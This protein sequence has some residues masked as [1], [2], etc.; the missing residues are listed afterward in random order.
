MML[1]CYGSSC[2]DNLLSL[3]GHLRKAFQWLRRWVGVPLAFAMLVFIGQ[4]V[5]TGWT[6]I[7]A[8]ASQIRREWLLAGIG[9]TAA[10]IIMLGWN[11]I[12]I[13]IGRGMQVYW[14]NTMALYLLTNLTRYLPGGIWHFVGRT[15]SL[16][17]QG[18]GSRSVIASLVL[19]QMM[20]L[21]SA[22]AIGFSLSGLNIHIALAAGL[23][24][25]AEIVLVLLAG[26]AAGYVKP[27]Y[28]R[29]S[30]CRRLG[31]WTLLTLSYNLF[32]IVNGSATVCLFAALV[33][34]EE[35]TPFICV[36]L[37]G[38]TA[39]SWAV[40]YMV[41]FVPGGWGVREVVFIHLLSRNFSGD[42]AIILPV[43]SRL[44]QILAE[45]LCGTIFLLA[46]HLVKKYPDKDNLSPQ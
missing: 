9:L 33:G 8:T 37:V 46:W 12:F 19:E 25:F 17:K 39:L 44:T 34:L 42:V 31:L 3:N 41:L 11:W 23:S 45:L 24:V 40:G 38:Q 7:Q 36:T 1:E 10:S 32:W 15:A 14:P 2:S 6:T 22:G 13:L 16:A 26:I 18:H 35:T 21:T 20:A 27:I 5:F 28:V 4:R 30:K 43:L 29:S